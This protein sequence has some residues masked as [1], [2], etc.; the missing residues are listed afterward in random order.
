MTEIL[1]P[2]SIVMRR[3]ADLLPYARN[4]RLHS[5]VQVAAIAGSMVEFGFTNPILVADNGILAGHGRVLAASLL[6]LTMVP[7][8]D[9]SRLSPIQRKAYVLADNKHAENA[10]WDLAMLRLEVMDLQLDDFDLSIVGFSLDDLDDL[11][12]TELLEPVNDPDAVPP[13]PEIAHS[14]PTDVWVCGPHK[15]MCGDALAITD[16]DALMGTE[17][18]DVVWTDPP[19][20]VD[21]GAKN[22]M[23]DRADKGNRGKTGGLK[24]D[25]MGDGA[26]HDFLLGAHVALYT[27]MKPGAAIYVAHADTE[28]FNFRNAFLRAGFK[29]SGCLIWQK[30]ILVIGRSDYQWMHEPVLY[31]WKPGAAHRWFGGRKQTTVGALGEASP[32]E[33][34]PDGTWLV[35]AGDQTFIVEGQA[36]V[37]KLE[38]S[39]IYHDKPRVSGLHPTTKPVGLLIKML[40][41]NARTN[42]IVADAFGGSGSTMIAAEQLGMCARLMEVDPRFCDVICRRYFE[43]TGR[44][45]VHAITGEEFPDVVEEA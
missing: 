19:Y 36:R 35:R 6:N 23:L 44:R 34:Q 20:N 28:G 21:I 5:D 38:S 40:R 15:V 25:K 31:G 13:L 17:K 8:I 16:W 2:E 3:L 43:F 12:A 22:E 33:P 29:L 27:V 41:N 39:V 9:L 7:T 14:R 26:F 4:A 10:T 32:F 30:N 11:F 42:D 37:E 24:N 45:A 1:M 18:A